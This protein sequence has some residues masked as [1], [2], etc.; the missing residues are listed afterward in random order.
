MSLIEELRKGVAARLAKLFWD[1]GDRPKIIQQIKTDP[2]RSSRGAENLYGGGRSSVENYYDYMESSTNRAARYDTYDA[3]DEQ[4]DIASVLDAYAEDATQLDHDTEQSIWIEGEDQNVVKSLNSFLHDTLRIDDWA[5]G[6]VRDIGKYGDDFGRLVIRNDGI[7][8]IEWMNPRDLERIENRDGYLLG[9]EWYAKL[10]EFLSKAARARPNETGDAEVLPTF[11]PWDIIHFRLFKRKRQPKERV[12]NIYGTSILASS[13]RPGKQVKIL[14]DILMLTRLVRAMD[15][16]IY[17]VDVGMSSLPEISQILRTWRKMMKRKTFIDPVAGSTDS[18]YDPMHYTD[19]IFLPTKDGSNTDISTIPGISNITDIADIDNFT[20]K[21]YGSL[22]A[23]KNYFGYGEGAEIQ[24][25]MSAQSIKWA[26]SVASL[27]KAF[28]NGI[29]RI[30]EIELSL[31]GMQSSIDKFKVMMAK[32]SYLEL[33]E[34]LESWQL[35]IDI[36]DRMF[37]LGDR[38]GFDRY[39][40]IEYILR[41]VL[42][43]SKQEIDMLLRNMRTGEE[44]EGG[45]EGSMDHGFEPPEEEEE[46][47]PPESE[48]GEGAT[49]EPGG[50]GEVGPELPELGEIPAPESVQTELARLVEAFISRGKNGHSS[51]QLDRIPS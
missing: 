44:V 31:R 8:S 19:D 27:Q 50:P 21:L 29:T 12:R 43:L 17:K 49:A 11:D 34:K 6:S 32:P 48:A 22:R 39:T 51:K 28:R 35:T 36:A 9:F 42:W 30:C 26:K 38:F 10:E 40:W 5:E 3:M 23:P 2:K 46:L 37:E 7:D 45:A 14:D 15:R 20:A 47:V 16:H 18:R 25:S 1:R 24:K 41:N 4:S 33:L 13:E